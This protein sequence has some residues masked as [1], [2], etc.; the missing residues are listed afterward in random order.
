[1]RYLIR[2]NVALRSPDERKL[3]E[4]FS[5]CV[6]LTDTKAEIESRINRKFGWYRVANYS[7][8]RDI[9]NDYS[10]IQ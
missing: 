10:A 5:D 3:F 4:F 2:V 7:Y 8:E 1:V 6:R 9:W